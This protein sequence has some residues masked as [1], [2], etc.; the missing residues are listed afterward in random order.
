M[1]IKL[2]PYLSIL[3]FCII[4]TGC[5]KNSKEIEKTDPNFMSFNKFKEHN[6]NLFKIKKE[7]NA[8]GIKSFSEN[9]QNDNLLQEIRDYVEVEGGYYG[10]NTFDHIVVS[11]GILQTIPE[12]STPAYFPITIPDYNY[13]TRQLVNNAFNELT[14]VDAIIDYTNDLPLEINLELKRINDNVR[15]MGLNIVNNYANTTDEPVEG[16][17]Q[18]YNTIKFNLEEQAN[19]LYS[20]INA[21]TEL[22]CFV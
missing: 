15:D 17:M 7:S 19:S 20:T 3:W 22:D 10:T 4:F 6:I 11:D 1:R 9:F 21:S 13:E 2:N 5:Q 14:N 8:S 18:I 16:D 12:Y